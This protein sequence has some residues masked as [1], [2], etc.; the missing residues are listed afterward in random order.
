MPISLRLLLLSEADVD[1]DLVLILRPLGLGGRS[2]E[3]ED[4]S[5]SSYTTGSLPLRCVTVRDRREFVVVGG[6]LSRRL[7][8]ARRPRWD[9]EA[10]CFVLLLALSGICIST[11]AARGRVR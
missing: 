11:S 7:S 6:M 10:E 4:S 8:D 5:S 3:V 1:G 2:R 9:E